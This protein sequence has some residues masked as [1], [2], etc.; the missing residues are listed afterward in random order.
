MHVS[1]VKSRTCMHVCCALSVPVPGLVPALAS[2]SVLSVSTGVFVLTV[3][4]EIDRPLSLSLCLPLLS[5]VR[6]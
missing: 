2:V 5:C 6:L 4:H 3:S 1:M